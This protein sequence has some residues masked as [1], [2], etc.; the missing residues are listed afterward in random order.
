MSLPNELQ[1]L[2]I[3]V[4]KEVQKRMSDA[5]TE[6]HDMQE[7]MAQIQRELQEAKTTSQRALDFEFKVGTDYQ[8][9]RCWVLGGTRSN[10]TPIPGNARE[11]LFICRA[12]YFEIAIPIDAR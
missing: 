9:P 11:D 7:R 4:A 12:C 1:R 6:L 3:E 10:I 5:Q 2:A 8:C